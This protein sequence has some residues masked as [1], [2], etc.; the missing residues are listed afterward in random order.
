MKEKQCSH[1]RADTWYSYEV[2]KQ[3]N[4]HKGH[5]ISVHPPAY[6]ISENTEQISFQLLTTQYKPY[7][8]MTLKLN[9][10]SLMFHLTVTLCRTSTFEVHQFD[11]VSQD[12]ACVICPIHNVI[13]LVVFH[14]KYL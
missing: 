14:K 6:P 11:L 1:K 12:I 9:V 7:L 10:I 13:F 5:I 8:Y 4:V 2:H 3:N